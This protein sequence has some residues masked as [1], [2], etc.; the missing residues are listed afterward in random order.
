[1]AA[2]ATPMPKGYVPRQWAMQPRATNTEQ[3]IALLE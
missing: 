1:M 3:A 2:E